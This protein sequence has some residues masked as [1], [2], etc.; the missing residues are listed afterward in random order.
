MTTFSM[1]RSTWCQLRT[2]D[3]WNNKGTWDWKKAWCFYFEK[4]GCKQDVTTHVIMAE[5]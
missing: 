5:L 3:K 4:L 1:I 2:K